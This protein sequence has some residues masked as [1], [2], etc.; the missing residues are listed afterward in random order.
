MKLYLIAYFGE[1]SQEIETC[2]QDEES[3]VY[4]I[5]DD[6]FLA[7]GPQCPKCRTAE[8]ENDRINS[9]LT[10][11]DIGHFLKKKYIPAGLDQNWTYFKKHLDELK[12]KQN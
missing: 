1:P 7:K 4:Y 8:F 3:L 9:F 11:E 12:T 2:K 5:E 6:I 10:I